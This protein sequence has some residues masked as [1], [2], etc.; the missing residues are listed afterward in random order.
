MAKWGGHQNSK[1]NNFRDSF[2]NNEKE[3]HHTVK[4]LFAQLFKGNNISKIFYGRIPSSHFYALKKTTFTSLKYPFNAFQ[5]YINFHS[6]KKSCFSAFKKNKRYLINIS[7]Q[8]K[9]YKDTFK[10]RN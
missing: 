1:N 9:K 4:D 6:F 8:K 5:I 10:K 2:L 7:Q 3:F